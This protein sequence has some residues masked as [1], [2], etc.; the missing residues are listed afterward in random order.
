M[1]IEG[2]RIEVSCAACGFRS[3]VR[4][5]FCGQCGRPLAAGVDQPPATWSG[6]RER[7]QLTILFCDLAGSTSL[8]TRLD[9]EEF[10]EVISQYFS[11][12]RAIF[13]RHRGYVDREEGDSLRV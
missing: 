2:E 11:L 10:G 5:R 9:A 6:Q 13:E 12:C 3:P 8:S 4:F 1:A 7:R